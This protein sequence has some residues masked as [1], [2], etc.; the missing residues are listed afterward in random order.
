MI[1]KQNWDGKDRRKTAIEVAEDAI[2]TAD[3]AKVDLANHVVECTA[4]YLVLN[5]KVDVQGKQND[6]IEKSVAKIDDKLDKIIDSFDEKMDRKVAAMKLEVTEVAKTSN[7]RWNQAL[8]G[9]L[10][11]TLGILGWGIDHY[12][13]K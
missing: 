8:I 10:T 3:G 5:S 11:L 2:D 6:R 1:D 7:D 9:L 13:I 12:I 4:R